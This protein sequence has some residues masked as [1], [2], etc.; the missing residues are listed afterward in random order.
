[1]FLGAT[2]TAARQL[3]EPEL[4]IIAGLLLGSMLVYFRY[5]R[6]LAVQGPQTRPDLLAMPEMLGGALLMALFGLVIFAKF[7]GQKPEPT[8]ITNERLLDSMATAALPAIAIVVLLVAR[9]GHVSSVF[10]LG[11]VGLFRAIGVGFC[12]AILALPLT[13]AAKAITMAV[14]GSK[15]APQILV[16]K[17]QS[18][19]DGGDTQL[20]M[21]I[22]IS[23][24]VIA[25]ITE[26]VL[27]RGTFYPMMTRWFGRFPAAILCACFFAAVHDTYTDAPGLIVLAL[28][29]TLAYE[30]TGSL[31]V[32][33]VMH[34]VFNGI[35]LAVLWWQIRHGF[36]P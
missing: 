11:K 27:F 34:M 28:C 7:S 9:G 35:S 29:F 5:F 13:Y 36:T 23:A 32:P 8:V 4:V 30:V 12:L 2:D 31:L 6:R 1:V 26:E 14:S 18:A 3:S 15:E 33:I 19:A 17:F 20:I 10:G 16:Q 22:A 24:C 21:L 25:P